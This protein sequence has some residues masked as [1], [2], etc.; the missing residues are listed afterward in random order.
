[1]FS[2]SRHALAL[3]QWSGFDIRHRSSREFGKRTSNPKLHWKLIFAGGP[4]ILTFA[5]VSAATGCE[6]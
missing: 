4:L 3:A 2:E 6:C 5:E 1:V